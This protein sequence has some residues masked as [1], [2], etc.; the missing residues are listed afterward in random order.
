M[1]CQENTTRNTYFNGNQVCK[2]GQWV[3]PCQENTFKDSGNEKQVCKQNQW[4]TICQ[5][6]QQNTTRI[7][8]SGRR[9]ICKNQGWIPMGDGNTTSFYYY[10][11]PTTIKDHPLFWG[12]L[13]SAFWIEDI[14]FLTMVSESPL[15]QQPSFLNKIFDIFFTIFAIKTKKDFED[16]SDV[17]RFERLGYIEKKITPKTLEILKLFL[18]KNHPQPQQTNLLS[19]F[20]KVP[21]TF[22]SMQELTGDEK[23]NC[24]QILDYLKTK[25][26][27]EQS[28]PLIGGKRQPKKKRSVKKRLQRKNKSKVRRTILTKTS[29]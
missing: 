21:D 14:T 3:T 29:L 9:D 5:P 24:I 2:K 19:S 22:L 23:T 20:L 4:L 10:T 6:N 18:E 15:L 27:I 1:S 17:S 8:K 26:M 13:K 12:E 28:F 11:D 25:S 7:N 16:N